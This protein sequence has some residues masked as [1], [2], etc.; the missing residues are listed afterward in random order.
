MNTSEGTYVTA[1][2]Q[3]LALVDTTSF[4]VAGYFKETQLPHIQVGQ[5]AEVVIIGYE[6]NPFQGGVRSIGW[7]IYVQDGSG[8]DA[9]DLLPFV[10]QTI[11]WVALPQS[12][13]VR[14][15]FLGKPPVP[16]GS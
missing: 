5:K 7:G 4:W 12:F 16:F 15:R 9:T 6:N 14:L 13:P 2:K 3:L 8:S 10:T 11:D 1:G